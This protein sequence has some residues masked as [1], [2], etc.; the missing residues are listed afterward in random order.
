MAVDQLQRTFQ[1]GAFAEPAE[2]AAE[3]ADL[4]TTA[5]LQPAADLLAAAGLWERLLPHAA[6]LS[7]MRIVDAGGREAKARLTRDFDAADISDRPFGWNVPNCSQR[8]YSSP[9][10]G[11]PARAAA[12]AWQPKADGVPLKLPMSWLT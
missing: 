11:D 4:R 10:T 1:R 8:A 6:P 3:G 9:G 2:L 5:F 7:V 12:T